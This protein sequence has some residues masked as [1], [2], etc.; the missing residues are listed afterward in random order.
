MNRVVL[1][2]SRPFIFDSKDVFRQF[3]EEE[4]SL[5]KVHMHDQGLLTSIFL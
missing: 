1:K 5:P 4:T 2:I 3:L